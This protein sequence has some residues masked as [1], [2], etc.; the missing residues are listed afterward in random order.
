MSQPGAAGSGNQA[1]PP[2]PATIPQVEVDDVRRQLAQEPNDLGIGLYNAGTGEIH[3][4]T[5]DATGQC[6]HDGLQA[7]LGI[8][9]GE[10]SMW[11]GFIF[12][13]GGPAINNSGFNIQ[14]GSPPRMAEVYFDQVEAALRNAG[15]L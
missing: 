3:I 11:R 7:L 13:L 12:R 5:Y 4:G 9:D 1:Q 2:A 6:G 10:R 15:L 14:D 8:A